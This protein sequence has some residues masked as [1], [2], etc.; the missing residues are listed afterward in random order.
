M[1]DNCILHT[2]P[3]TVGDVGPAMIFELIWAKNSGNFS[4][5][6][7][8]LPEISC[9][10]RRAE[11]NGSRIQILAALQARF[12]IAAVGERETTWR[13]RTNMRALIPVD[14]MLNFPASFDCRVM[15]TNA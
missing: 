1:P 7:L 12:D 13:M 14:M 4:I 3:V 11:A 10:S 6:N 5:V 8:K 2:G 15:L 9:N